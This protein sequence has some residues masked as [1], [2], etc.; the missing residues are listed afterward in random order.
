MVL[1]AA[2]TIKF[3]RITSNFTAGAGYAHVV[4]FLVNPGA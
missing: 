2:E 4:G 3:N 1:R